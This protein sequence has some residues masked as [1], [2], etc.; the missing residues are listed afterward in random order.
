[1]PSPLL[2]IQSEMGH[3]VDPSSIDTERGYHAPLAREAPDD[4]QGLRA[5]AVLLVVLGH[6]GVGFLAGGFIGVDVFFVLSGFLITGLLLTE[7]A[8]RRYLSLAGFYLRRARRILPAATVT[9]VATSVAA[10]YLLNFVRGKEYLTDSIW[11]SVFAANY[12]WAVRQVKS[13]HPNA[14]II[15][16]AYS[17]SAGAK[18]EAATSG[19]SSLVSSARRASK[20]CSLWATSPGAASSRSTACSAGKPRS[21][22]ARS[23]R[24]PRIST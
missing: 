24:P 1:M 20:K 17:N 16:G 7:V 22:A 14:T 12:R 18:E 9:L 19:I 15:G 8:Q 13:L 3:T 4:I 2:Q 23:R 10:Y 5:V 11:A 6:A 21:P